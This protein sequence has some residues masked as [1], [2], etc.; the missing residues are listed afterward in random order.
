MGALLLSDPTPKPSGCSQVGLVRVGTSVPW[1]VPGSEHPVATDSGLQ[2]P[3][4]WAGTSCWCWRRLDG[5]LEAEIRQELSPRPEGEQDSVQLARKDKQWVSTSQGHVGAGT[6]QAQEKTPEREQ[7][8]EC[9]HRSPRTPALSRGE[10]SAQQPQP[11]GP[12]LGTAVPGT[13]GGLQVSRDGGAAAPRPQCRRV[14]QHLV[15]AGQGAGL[16]AVTAWVKQLSTTR[17]AKEQN[18]PQGGRSGGHGGGG[19]PH[20]V[21]AQ[22]EAKLM[23]KDN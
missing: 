18:S 3:G 17:V 10:S 2:H 7:R 4:L 20:C 21:T 23:G 12:A 15:V 19:C 6:A 1:W 22:T 5:S 14:W 8:G 9:T 13:Q 16:P 11:Q